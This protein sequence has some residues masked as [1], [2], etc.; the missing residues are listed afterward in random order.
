ME[1]LPAVPNTITWPAAVVIVT[2]LLTRGPV[3]EALAA[4]LK[5]GIE[6]RNGNGHAK[7]TAAEVQAQIMAAEQAAAKRA[8]LE[9]EVSANTKAIDELCTQ[10]NGA[11]GL[12]HRTRELEVALAAVPGEIARIARE[13]AEGVVLGIVQRIERRREAGGGGR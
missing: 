4:R 6:A 2:L 9:A 12:E 8:R 10:L 7:P 3:G 11:D 1:G 13:A 5:R